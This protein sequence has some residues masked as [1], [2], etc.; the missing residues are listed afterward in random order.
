MEDSNDTNSSLNQHDEPNKPV[1]ENTPNK[2]GLSAEDIA[3]SAFKKDTNPPDLD[4]IAEDKKD[5]PKKKRFSLKDLTKKQKI[6]IAIA[7]AVLL[8]G[9]GFALW[10]FVIRDKPQQAVVEV[11]EE[12][13]V[14]TTVPSKLTG[15]QVPPEYNERTVTAVM[16]ENSPDARP[17]SGLKD[18]GVVYEAIAEGG[19]TRFMAVYQDTEP[20]YV[21]PVRSARPYYLRWALPYEAGYAHVGGSPEA[22]AEIK[23]LGVRD[24]DQFANSGAFERVSSRYAPHNVYTGI[25]KLRVVE[26]EKGWTTS[27]FTGFER[28]EETPVAATAITAKTI[29]FAISSALYN[30]AYTYDP[31]TNSY[32]RAQGGSP[33]IDEKANAQIS[34]KVVVALVMNKGIASDGQHST[35]ETIGSG[36][37]F[38]FQDGGVQQGTWKKDSDN[39]QFTFLDANGNALKLNPGQTWISMVGGANLVTYQ[40]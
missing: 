21:G 5:M 15:L 39:A 24:L 33:H 40:P 34:P 13:P 8:I 22:L 1:T 3:N 20:D 29:N 11:V 9:G 36:Q 38:V 18:A 17:Q 32:L 2:T 7:A 27:N 28:K 6:I 4:A 16:I 25:A 10:W 37:M 26:A 31:A 14:P 12:V 30:V 23:S 19:I 35:Y